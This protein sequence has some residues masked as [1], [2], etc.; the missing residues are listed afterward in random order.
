MRSIEDEFKTNKGVIKI[1]FT[2][3]STKTVRFLIMCVI[4]FFGLLLST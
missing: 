1:G 3:Y 2:Y 4:C